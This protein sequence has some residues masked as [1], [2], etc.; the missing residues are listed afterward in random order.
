MKEE[1]IMCDGTGRS[2]DDDFCY[3]CQGEGMK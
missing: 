2:S 3:W 1:C